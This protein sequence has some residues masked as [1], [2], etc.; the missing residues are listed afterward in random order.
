MDCLLNSH[1]VFVIA[2]E[3]CQFCVGETDCRVDR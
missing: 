2:N 3:A 1:D